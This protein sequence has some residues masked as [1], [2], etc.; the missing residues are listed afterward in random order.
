MAARRPGFPPSAPEPARIARIGA[1]GDGVATLSDGTLLFVPFTLPGELAQ[2]RRIGRRGGGFAATADAIVE[3]SAGRVV[4]PCPHFG[5]CGGCT[6]Q[7]WDD[8]PYRAW[9]TELLRAALRR[10]GYEANPA[11]IA[12]TPP[13]ARRRIDFAI[14][15]AEGSVRLGLHVAHGRAL[16]DIRECTVLHPALA[17]LL[18]PMRALLPTLSGLRREGTVIANLLDT[19]PDLLLRTDAVLTA[20]DR[21]RLAN[22][23]RAHAL[24]RIA[25]AHG[26]D[27]PEIAAQ[28]CPATVTFGGVAVSPPPGAFLQA[29]VAGEAAIVA[30]VLGGLPERMAA[31]ARVADL[32]AG[33]GTLTFP[34]AARARIA[35]FEGDAAATAALANAA[36]H[37]GLA[38]RITASR[39]DLARQPLGASELA[40]FAALVLDPPH[41]GAAAQVAQIALS[42][43]ARVVYVSCNPATL[44]RDAATL[45][46]AGYRLLSA[47]PI[48]QFRWSARLESVT[49]FAR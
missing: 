21:A 25:W 20:A 40:E 15:R 45:R 43:V 48:D 30:G 18:A 32:Y 8:A 41:A 9:K 31:R 13:G 44:A 24:P 26:E 10:A 47:R 22:F 3:P 6:L 14:R 35:A 46:L 5:T 16:V 49:V 38:G 2:V 36:N 12:A 28:L 1:E 17:A 7:H 23:A 34:L 42:R 11:P 19:G 4:P 39:R 37:A 27:A 33:S 29:S